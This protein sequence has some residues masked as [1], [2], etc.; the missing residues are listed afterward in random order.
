MYVSSF[1]VASVVFFHRIQYIY[2]YIDIPLQ[3]RP[4]ETTLLTRFS[5]TYLVSPCFLLMPEMRA[6]GYWN[7]ELEA[8]NG[9]I[10]VASVSNKPAVAAVVR[11][12]KR[13]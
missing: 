2:I 4:S 12:S 1:T 13:R 9:V 7:A 10:A 6:D 3:I 11:Q 5:R 8:V